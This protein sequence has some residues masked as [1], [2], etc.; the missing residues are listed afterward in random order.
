MQQLLDGLKVKALVLFADI[1]TDGNGVIDREEFLVAMQQLQHALSDG[2]MQL[3]FGCMESNGCITPQQV[4]C[5][6]CAALRCNL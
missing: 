2:E 6:S 3:V 1:D 4:R 5:S